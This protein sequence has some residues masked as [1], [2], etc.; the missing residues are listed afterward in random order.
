MLAILPL[1]LMR[2]RQLSVVPAACCDCLWLPLCDQKHA[3]AFRFGW[4]LLDSPQDG[5]VR[6]WQ[7][8]SSS[9]PLQVPCYGTRTTAATEAWV[10]ECVASGRGRQVRARTAGSHAGRLHRAQVGCQV[11]LQQA[12]GVGGEGGGG[13]G[14][15]AWPQEVLCTA[16]QAG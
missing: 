14:R 5:I 13:G 15:R 11:D 4:L 8:D 12:G 3:C 1:N 7:A 10:Q 2:V 9:T 6:K 16:A